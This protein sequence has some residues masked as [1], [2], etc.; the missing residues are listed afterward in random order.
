MR[1]VLMFIPAAA[2]AACASHAVTTPALTPGP[3]VAQN[4]PAAGADERTM[5]RLSIDSA[6][7][8]PKF[9]NANWGILIVDP[10]SGDT[11]YSRNAGKLFM[12]ASNMKIITGSAALVQ[13]GPDYRYRTTFV[14]RGTIRD[15]TL[16]GD[17]L[18]IGRGDPT[19]SDHMRKD[20][21]APLRDIADSLRAHGITRITGR[22][23][24][25]GDAFPGPTLGFGWDWD[26]LDYDYG[27]G[28]DELLFNEGFA[29]IIAR[30]GQRPGAPVTV[31]TRP[32]RKSPKVRVTATTVA[33]S[34]PGVLPRA[35]S[36]V[37]RWDSVGGGA[38]VEG[39]IAVGDSTSDN[40]AYRV[41][42]ASY[43]DAL[44]EAL[45][46]RAIR[47]DGRVLR[48]TVS[49]GDT[50]FTTLSPPLREILPALEKPSQNQI[51]EVLFKTLA[52]ERTGV[53]SADSARKV[54][55]QQ[56][57]AW[58][59]RDGGY[60]IRDGSGLSRHDYVT[61][62]T[63]VR[64][65]TAIRS[66]SAFQVFYD[67]LPIAGVDGTISNRMKG[68][69]A[70]GNVHAKTGFVDKARSLSGYATTVDGHMVIFSALCNNWTVPTAEVEA[71]QNMIAARLAGMRLSVATQ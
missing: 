14:A 50:L 3:T 69:P 65:L 67:A 36:P 2:L 35:T 60:A 43:V 22:I 16:R 27:A 45:Q 52:L 31:E 10:G 26:D 37:F 64:V 4:I 28:V 20:A 21:M 54:I 17:L 70:E 40:V 9:A 51:A 42:D 47:L 19:V 58:G 29:T 12:P 41:P 6:V 57:V 66:D 7:N 71:V 44:G 25:A 30:G 61:P 55:E 11:L 15:S 39:T 56:L 13:L 8:A 46:E 62:E 38:L 53:G 33:A 32:A 48:D 59:A 5:L 34:A 63:L 49:A 18:V 1:L 68:T 23:V 24:P